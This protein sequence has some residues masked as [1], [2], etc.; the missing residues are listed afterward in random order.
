[1][2]LT[3]LQDPPVNYQIGQTLPLDRRILIL[4]WSRPSY[5]QRIQQCLSAWLKLWLWTLSKEHVIS[6]M[7]QTRKKKK[8]SI[9]HFTLTP[10]LINNYPFFLFF[11]RNILTLPGGNAFMIRG[12]HPTHQGEQFHVKCS[13]EKMSCECPQQYI[14]EHLL[15][16]LTIREFRSDCKLDMNDKAML[17]KL[18]R[19]E[20]RRG[21]K[22]GTKKH[23]LRDLKTLADATEVPKP[24]LYAKY[25][26][27]AKTR[28]KKEPS[29]KPT[30]EETPLTGAA[31]YPLYTEDFETPATHAPDILSPGAFTPGVAPMFSTPGPS[32]ST[33]R[34]EKPD[35][36]YLLGKPEKTEEKLGKSANFLTLAQYI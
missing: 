21:Y 1:M 36:Q 32:K 33:K 28:K 6:T 12:A 29:P 8:Y 24:K 34:S 30:P 4:L 19:E 9:F 13:A 5:S 25:K 18:H 35:L 15:V 16:A 10:Q 23:R 17:N 27:K 20:M 11:F 22:A 26:E 31:P 2:A 14:C 7:A 3:D